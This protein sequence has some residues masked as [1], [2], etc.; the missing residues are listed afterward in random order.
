MR[1]G[2]ILASATPQELRRDTG[3]DDL[4]AAFLRM[5]ERAEAGV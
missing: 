5:I 2:R 4:G 1:D 3:E